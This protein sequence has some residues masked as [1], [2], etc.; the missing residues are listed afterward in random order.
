MKSYPG[1]AAGKGHRVSGHPTFVQCKFLLCFFPG[2]LGVT[3]GFEILN[4]HSENICQ[5]PLVFWLHVTKS[6]LLFCLGSVSLIFAKANEL[7]VP[8][9]PRS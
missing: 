8:K 2:L 6:R 5:S 9:Y 4:L 3:Y 1:L 7:R